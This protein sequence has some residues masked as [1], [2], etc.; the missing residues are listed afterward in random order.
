MSNSLH[1]DEPCHE[2]W[3][4]MS[5]SEKGRFCMSCQ[6][7]VVDFTGKPKEEI[8]EHLSAASGSTCG[9]VYSHQLGAEATAI[10]CNTTSPSKFKFAYHLK[11]VGF[12]LLA[13]MGF[14]LVAQDAFAQGRVSIKK[15]KMA[16]HP[17]Q[18]VS[19][20]NTAKTVIEGYIKESHS[21]KGIAGANVTIESNGQ[22]IADAFTDEHGFYHIEVEPGKI[23]MNKMNIRAY[24]AEYMPVL[25]QDI[26]VGKTKVTMNVEMDYGMIMLGKMIAEPV[27]IDTIEV[28][29]TEVTEHEIEPSVGWDEDLVEHVTEIMEIPICTIQVI[30]P[31]IPIDTENELL[32]DLE[33]D[34]EPDTDPSNTNQSENA[35]A[36]NADDTPAVVTD[37]N[38]GKLYPNPVSDECSLEMAKPNTYTVEVFDNAGRH[39]LSENFQGTTCN[40]DV[41]NLER[42][43]YHVRIIAKEGDYAQTLEL[44][45]Q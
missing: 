5:A 41:A 8:I 39:V 38:F 15:G 40:L 3:N 14:T 19:T 22:M 29:N 23:A 1:I 13:F 10:D 33:E 7:E 42:G 4:A 26:P 27:K 43:V 12:S 16:Y 2:N 28:I 34:L 17:R 32:D 6:K 18:E 44:V 30:E 24:S 36:M 20:A 21:Q 35:V 31:V 25:M 11:S 9:R 45:V 37:N